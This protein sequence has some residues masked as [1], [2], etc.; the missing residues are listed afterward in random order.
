[1]FL[2]II[3]FEIKSYFHKVILE[4]SGKKMEELAEIKR[5]TD[6][7]IYEPGIQLLLLYSLSFA[8][9]KADLF[10][11]VDKKRKT[12]NGYVKTLQT[13]HLTK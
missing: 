3:D 12:L 6:I 1:M 9:C 11:E 5:N 7:E 4:N 10:C 2:Y 13:L 8:K